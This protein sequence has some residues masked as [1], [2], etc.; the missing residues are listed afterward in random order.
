MIRDHWTDLWSWFS[1]TLRMRLW[2]WSFAPMV[3]KLCS[4]KPAQRII[5][6]AWKMI[7]VDDTS[8]NSKAKVNVD[9]ASPH[10]GPG[11]SSLIFWQATLYFLLPETSYPDYKPNLPETSYPDYK[12]NLPETSYPD[13]KPNLPETSYPD[14]KPNLL[15]TS[16]PDYKPKKEYADGWNFEETAQP[17]DDGESKSKSWYLHISTICFQG[18]GICFRSAPMSTPIHMVSEKLYMKTSY[19]IIQIPMTTYYRKHASTMKGHYPIVLHMWEPPLP[20]Q[21]G[22]PPTLWSPQWLEL[23][24]ML[25][26]RY[27]QL[28]P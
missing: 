15:E 7:C 18:Q 25:Q 23:L 14:H 21:Q 10:F 16:Y 28:C 27:S 13:Y 24:Q 3:R 5:G 6:C 12:P 17:D 19:E 8:L 11:R 2:R 22:K 26:L 1:P 20:L 4:V 9:K